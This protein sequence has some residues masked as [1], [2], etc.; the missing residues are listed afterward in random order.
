MEQLYLVITEKPKLTELIK[1]IDDGV[2]LDEIAQ[3]E[4]SYGSSS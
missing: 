4:F 2:A 3:K 1:I